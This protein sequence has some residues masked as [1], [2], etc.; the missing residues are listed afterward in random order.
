MC[1]QSLFR[2]LRDGPRHEDCD[3]EVSG[4]AVTSPFST[5]AD[6]VKEIAEVT[7]LS[8]A[9]ERM[10]RVQIQ[11]RGVRDPRVL[12]AMR[13]VPREVFVAPGL[14]EFA[15]IWFDETTAVTPLGPAHARPGEPD[16]YPFAL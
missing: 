4:V 11:G 9:R 6:R 12:A 14:E 16:T 3:R 10:V 7:D 13:A 2:S 15:F 1:S 5:T 8:Q